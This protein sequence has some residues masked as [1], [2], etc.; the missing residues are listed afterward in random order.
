MS[1]KAK[2]RNIES[3]GIK[4][5]LHEMMRSEGAQSPWDGPP[6]GST[7][8]KK[9]LWILKTL[10]CRSFDGLQSLIEALKQQ[11]LSECHADA[12]TRWIQVEKEWHEEHIAPGKNNHWNYPLGPKILHQLKEAVLAARLP[13]TNLVVQAARL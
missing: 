2:N 10:S 13:D 3:D 5:L 9:E 4:F 11:P 12:I 6:A 1:S 8:E 7:E